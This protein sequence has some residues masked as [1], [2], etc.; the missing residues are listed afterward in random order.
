MTLFCLATARAEQN[1]SAIKFSDPSKPG[2]LK[3]VVLHGDLRIHGADVNEVLVK[4]S[5]RAVTVAPR[6]DGLR[7]LTAA[8]SF[9][10]SEK[11]NIITLDAMSEGWNSP[12]V[13]LDI[14]VPRTTAI[15]LSNANGG[16][17]TCADVTGDLDIKSHNGGE[18]RLDNIDGGALVET[19]NGEIRATVRA[20]HEGKPLSFMTQN[21][22]VTLKIPSEVKANVRLRTQNGSILT[23][24]DDKVLVTKTE[25]VARTP[26]AKRANTTRRNSTRSTETREE[27]QTTIHEAAQA[28]IDAAREAASAVREAAQ[29]AR[30]ALQEARITGD[31]N[32][33]LAVPP[34]PPLP[35]MTG[36]KI[37]SGTLN[38]GGPEIQ[39]ATMNGDVTL[40]KIEAKK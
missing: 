26:K 31:S 28:S 32:A 20:L 22:E 29:A 4:S 33:V 24:F 5:A 36:G 30:E 35:P 39:I 34:M 40:R 7:V 23:D 3:V 6:K 8:F 2:T 25:A 16:D 27:I 37:V 38:G 15:I 13:D 10:L 18:I 1:E 21:G 11:E 14:T 9:G 19:M 17:I 12:P